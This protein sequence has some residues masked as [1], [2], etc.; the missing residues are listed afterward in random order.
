MFE[1]EC[2]SS[3]AKDSM[4]GCSSQWCG[5]YE[6]K[7]SLT[8]I[9]PPTDDPSPLLLSQEQFC[10]PHS[11]FSWLIPSVSFSVQY[12][13][14]HINSSTLDGSGYNI[15]SNKRPTYHSYYKLERPQWGNKNIK[16]KLSKKTDYLLQPTLK[17]QR[18][19][20]QFQGW[21]LQQSPDMYASQLC[22][23]L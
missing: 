23:T 9:H 10:A 14:H 8:K 11:W 1:F 5:L 17:F 12:L 21:M 20:W 3:S 19:L 22:T 6:V 2:H 13:V 7:A 16:N 4:P 15:L 18:E